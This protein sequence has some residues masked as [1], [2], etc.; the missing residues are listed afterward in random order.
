M[1]SHKDEIVHIRPK[2][3]ETDREKTIHSSWGDVMDSEAPAIDRTDID[4]FNEVFCLYNLFTKDECAR[5]IQASEETGY[6]KTSYPPQYRGN[7]RL[8]SFD[9]SL[10]NV[11]FERIKDQLPETLTHLGKDGWRIHSMNTKFRLAKYYPGHKFDT[12]VDAAFGPRKDFRS[13]YTVNI[14]INDDF[15]GGSTRFYQHGHLDKH[16]EAIKPV[17]GM[18][19]IFRQPPKESHYH[20][21]EIVKSGIKYLLRTD[22]MYTCEETL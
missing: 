5:L 21:G 3:S 11:I 14:Y 1:Q 4:G 2:I 12:H 19:L 17:S 7:L 10:A 8:M 6:G 22:V 9:D 20:D 16:C 13:F 18:A 15:T